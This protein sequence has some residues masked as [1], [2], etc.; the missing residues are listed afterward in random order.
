ISQSRTD[1]R[2]V[3]DAILDSAVRLLGAYS[4][5]LTRVA[6]D[7]L[8]LVALT[9]TDEAGDAVM[10]ASF[11]RSLRPEDAHA[12]AISTRAPLNVADAHT[13]RRLSDAEHDI[14]RARGYHSRVVVPMVRYDEAVGTIAVTRRD[15][16]GFTDDEIALLKTFADQAVIAIENARL[17][18]E[19]Q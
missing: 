19:L 4:G 10:R 8:E 2:P 13:D 15:P 3:F 6:G 17:L 7:Q 1:V 12:R 14:A 11:P 9:S 5:S 18:S 16:G